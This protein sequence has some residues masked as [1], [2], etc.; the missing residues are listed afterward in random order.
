M[1]RLFSI[2]PAITLRGRAFK[3]LRGWAGKPLHPPLT[4]IPIAAY[5]FAAAFDLIS[6]IAG[7][8]SLGAHLFAAATYVLVGGLAVSLLTATTGFWDWWKGLDRDRTTGPIGRAKHTQ[9]W[10]TTNWHAVVMVFVTLVVAADMALHL[11]GYG[12]R[13][14]TGLELALSLIAAIVVMYGATYGG[15]LVFDYQ[16][17]VEQLEDWTVWEETEQDKMPGDSSG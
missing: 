9:V 7:P 3:G 11:A 17:N 2:R 4:D 12:N 14:S 8:G 6:L 15:S 13:P 10:R 16:F 5:V 1:P